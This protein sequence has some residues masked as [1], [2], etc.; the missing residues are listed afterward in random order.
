MRSLQGR[1]LAAVG[2]L[3]LAAVVGVGLAARQG[4]RREL[5]S[6][7][8]LERRGAV[9]DL[10][11][12]L[13]ALAA[14]HPGG[15][16]AAELQ[17]AAQWGPSSAAL[18][19][20]A[21]GALVAAAG[22]P[23]RGLTVRTRRAGQ[24]T[25]VTIESE[26]GR[27]LSELHLRGGGVPAR[28]AGG[29]PGCL[30]PL[31]LPSLREEQQR[32]AAL[33]A[34]DHRLL[35]ATAVAAALA[36]LSTWGL[37]RGVLAP[38]RQLQAATRDLARGQ[39]NRRVE[40]AGPSEIAELGHSLNRMAA[41]LER[42]QQLRR[43]LVNDVA[44]E[45]G[46]PLTTMVCRLEAVQ[47]GL[48]PNPSATLSGFRDDVLHLAGL[49]ADLQALAHAEAGQL[50]LD[51]MRTALMPA[52]NQA[53][54]A[55]GLAADPRIALRIDPAID[56]QADPKRLRQ[57][58]MNLLTNAARHTPP[59]GRIEIRAE[60][61]AEEVR[62]EVGDSGCG[63]SAEQVE[64]V[65]ERFYRTDLAR[66]RSTGGSGLGLAIVKTLVEA[67]G[68]RVWV[69]STLGSGANFGFALPRPG[70]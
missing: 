9:A 21:R 26:R 35:V 62:V 69:Q 4:A 63:L 45:L 27:Q 28:L 36:L 15:I 37:A 56:V 16:S 23:L 34:L 66:Q 32:A 51:C 30:L 12:E 2:V 14:A 43:D 19:V 59:G 53:L 68:G 25:I 44:H 42:Q 33:G 60:E 46:A 13:R 64:R 10:A 17:A 41:E 39:L 22:K 20:D 11:G 48:D 1:M 58:L 57:V 40:A 7:A 65:F 5:L 49:V 61:R 50:R 24:V 38:L 54:S 3:A 8:S 55:A 67:Q 70:D 29:R 52:A 47:D 31:L 6:F 18:L